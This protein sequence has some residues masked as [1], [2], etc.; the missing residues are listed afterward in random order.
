MRRFVVFMAG[1]LATA[2]PGLLDAQD[3]LR[4]LWHAPGDSATPSS[5][6]TVM[7]DRPVAGALDSSVRAAT[8][9]HITPFVAGAVFWRDPV[10]IR[11]VPSEPLS[12]AVRYTIAVDTTVRAAD[13]ARLAAPYRFEFR[14]AGPRLQSPARTHSRPTAAFVSSTARPSTS[15]GWR[16]VRASSCPAVPGAGA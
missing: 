14:V 5:T 10:T 16:V 15:I 11:F 9:F 8:V 1:L 7:F 6:V 13:G 2:G 4:V 12:P 3:T